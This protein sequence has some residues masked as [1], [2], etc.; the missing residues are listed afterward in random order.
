MKDDRT[1]LEVSLTTLADREVYRVSDEWVGYGTWGAI[2]DCSKLVGLEIAESDCMPLTGWQIFHDG[3]HNVPHCRLLRA[4]LR[5][6][7]SPLIQSAQIRWGHP[8][9]LP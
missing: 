9:Y 8:A 4:D 1:L 2:S 5:S 7:A 3:C 6:E